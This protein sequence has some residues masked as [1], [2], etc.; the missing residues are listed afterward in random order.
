M[1]QILKKVRDAAWWRET[2]PVEGRCS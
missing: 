2:T 1:F